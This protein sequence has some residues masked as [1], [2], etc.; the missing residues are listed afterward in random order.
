MHTSSGEAGAFIV[1]GAR[2][3]FAKSG[4][5]LSRVGAVDLGVAAVREAVARS[6]FLPAEVDAVIVGNVASPAN[7]AN[8]S[9][10]IAVGAGLPE[11][12]PAHTVNRNCASGMEAIM[13]AAHM[14]ESGHARVVVAGGVE[15]MSGIPLLFSDQF[16]EILFAARR[17][18]SWSAR[19]RSY[20][21]LRPRHF[22]PLVGLELGLTDPLCG[23]NMGQTA[24]RLAAE[25]GISREQQDALALESHRRACAASARLREEMT[26]LFLPPDGSR[27]LHEDVGP[28]PNQTAEALARLKPFFDKSRGTVTAGNSSPITDGAAAVVVASAE[29][30]RARPISSGPLA[31]V[32]SWANVGLAPRRMG[33]GP[34]FAMP[35]ALALAG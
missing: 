15:S 17:A 27:A 21:R 33:L 26:P 35:R 3:P 19:L 23:L 14:V 34:A 29:A 18:R 12:V 20:A 11:T 9:R 13:Q 32:R 25:F 16:K 8:I 24:E 30:V 1:A 31:R 2:T 10:V 28:R 22:K 4:T 5:T 7:A 6:G